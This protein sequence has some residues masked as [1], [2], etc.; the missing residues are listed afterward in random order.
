MRTSLFLRDPDID[1]FPTRKVLRTW[2]IS[3]RN[4]KRSHD[5]RKLK[6]SRSLP[7]RHGQPKAGSRSYTISE[8]S[9]YSSFSKLVQAV[10]TLIVLPWNYKLPRELITL[11]LI[12][13]EYLVP[14]FYVKFT[15]FISFKTLYTG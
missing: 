14:R 5:A 8:H 15:N 4:L 13:D 11:T 9:H 12:N 3:H 7:I 2:S 10:E 6:V 1:E